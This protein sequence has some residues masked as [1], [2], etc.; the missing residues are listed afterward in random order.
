MIN[1][2][3]TPT[4]EAFLASRHLAEAVEDLSAAEINRMNM[5]DY[6]EIRRRA[7]LPDVD[8]FTTAYS[9]PAPMALE[10]PPEPA[11]APPE[12]PGIDPNS[13]D[14]FHAWRANRT[15]GGEGF[16]IFGGSGLEQSKTAFGRSKYSQ[17]NV[18]EP[19]RLTDRYVRHDDMRDPRSAAERFTFPGSAFSL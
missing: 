17:S 8:P 12:S 13:D 4:Q 18:V 9:K 3:I 16:G 5:Q 6:R 7:G 14:Y 2:G 15:H 1:D 19:P 10:Q 11:L